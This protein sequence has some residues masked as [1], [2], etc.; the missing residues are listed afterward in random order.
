[1]KEGLG[2]DLECEEG[3]NTRKAR[4]KKLRESGVLNIGIR[5]FKGLKK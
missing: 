5:I 2:R 4:E 1:M 3:R